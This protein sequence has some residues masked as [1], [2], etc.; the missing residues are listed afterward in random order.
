MGSLIPIGGGADAEIQNLLNAAFNATNINI[1]RTTVANENLLDDNHHL[2]RIAYRLGTYPIGTYA[3]DDARGKWFYFLKHILKTARHNGEL[4]ATSIKKTLAY[5]VRNASGAGKVVRVVFTAIAGTD[6]TAEH[7]VA[8]GNPT[9]D[10]DIASLVD[11]TGT[12][13]IVLVCPHSLPDQSIPIPNQPGD[14]DVDPQGNV[15]EKKPVNI[16]APKDLSP[17]TLSPKTHKPITKTTKTTPAR[18]APK[19]AGKKAKA[20]KKKAAKAKKGR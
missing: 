9:S 11:T 1:V 8:P 12:L 13:R 4:T 3:G 20:K 7:Y 14:V 5:A 15:V 17:P 2:H 16:F 6:A 19:K 18:K 10:A